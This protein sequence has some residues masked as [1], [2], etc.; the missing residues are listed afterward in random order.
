[1]SDP[2]NIA[3]RPTIVY[4]GSGP[5][6]AKSL[7]Y[8]HTHFSVEAVITK[9]RAKHH[10]GPVPV[11]EFCETHKL[12]YFTPATK[13]ELSELFRHT[14]FTSRLGIVIDYGIII[15][16]E[17]IDSF[18]LGIINSHFSLLPEWRGADP[19][20]F[21]LLSGQTV[22]GVSLMLINEKM[23]EGALLAQ[24]ESPITPETT[25][26]Q[27]TEQLL[28]ISN[29][30]LSEIVPSY[31]AGMLQPVPQTSNILGVQKPSYSRK[32]TKADSV[33][34]WQKSAEQLEREVRAFAEWPKSRTALGQV[35]VTVTKAQ[36]IP[37]ISTEQVGKVRI[38][39]T[40]G[41][42][43]V[44]CGKGRLRLH[45][46]KPSGKNEMSTAEFIRGYSSR[47]A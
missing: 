17:V 7:Q 14:S 44:T 6:A 18:P 41:V 20:T 42:I 1:M 31:I 11:I 36:A 3:N 16:R 39:A 24:A 29:A 22:T 32:L 30:L 34:D 15:E 26:P 33:L 13:L 23:D 28:D 4:F 40:A 8:L 9:P 10:K 2:Q 12:R 46:L 19:I 21:S 37:V 5:L 45:A 25:T 43:E 27:L 35:D 47:L 38:D